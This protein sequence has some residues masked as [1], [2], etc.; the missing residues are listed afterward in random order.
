MLTL[1]GLIVSG[2]DGNPVTASFADLAQLGSTN[3]GYFN[4]LSKEVNKPRTY[5]PGQ[6]T[7]ESQAR[8]EETVRQLGQQGASE[9]PDMGEGMRNTNANLYQ[10]SGTGNKPTN[11]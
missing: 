2:A 1:N 11:Q 6:A 3:R 10:R 7:K 8:N 5:T 9:T 4:Q